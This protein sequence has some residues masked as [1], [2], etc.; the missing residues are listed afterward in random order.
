MSLESFNFNKSHGAFSEEN[1][2]T[3]KHAHYAIEIVYSTEGAFSTTTDGCHYGNLKS[4]IVP[5]GLPHRFS[6]IHAKC[7]LLFFEPTSDIGNYFM[8]KYD[9]ADQR[10]IVADLSE[11]A[12]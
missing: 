12:R 5:P 6:C 3:A 7:K 2:E 4:A 8:R 9:L 1:Y 11:A 10:T